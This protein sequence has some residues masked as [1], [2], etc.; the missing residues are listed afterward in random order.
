[1]DRARSCMGVEPKSC[2]FS[3]GKHM[4]NEDL[5]A[6]CQTYLQKEIMKA[7]PPFLAMR[8]FSRGDVYILRPTVAGI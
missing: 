2:Q 7:F 8:R 6:Q 3:T 1:M 5:L 4:E